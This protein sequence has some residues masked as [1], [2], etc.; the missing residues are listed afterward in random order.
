M[1]VKVGACAVVTHRR[2]GIR[3]PSGDLDVSE[4]DAGVEHRGDERVSEHVR[5]HAVDGHACRERELAWSAG[6]R[7]AIHAPAFAVQ[8]ERAGLATAGC[9]VDGSA[10]RWRQ[11]HEGDLVAFAMNA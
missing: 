2:S 3:V 1:A 6:G 4:V 11:W 8:Q 5:V 7:V 10:D 9:A